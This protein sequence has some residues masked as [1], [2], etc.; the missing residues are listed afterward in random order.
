MKQSKRATT[1]AEKTK[2]PKPKKSN[3]TVDKG[4]PHPDGDHEYR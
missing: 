4:N 1:K 2:K 3:K